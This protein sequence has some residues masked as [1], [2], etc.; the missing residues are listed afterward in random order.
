MVSGNLFKLLG[1]WGIVC[2]TISPRGAEKLLNLCLPIRQLP[3]KPKYSRPY[4]VKKQRW[5]Y[6]VFND[7]IDCPMTAFYPEVEAYVSVP[8]LVLTPDDQEISTVQ[9]RKKLWNKLLGKRLWWNIFV[10]MIGVKR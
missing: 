9:I 1:A 2:Y 6:P 5:R 10:K 7:A 8:P 4:R 3:L